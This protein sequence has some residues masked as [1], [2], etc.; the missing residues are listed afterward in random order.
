MTLPRIFAWFS[1]EDYDAIK[2]LS[3]ND[4]DLPDTFDEWLELATQ[5]VANLEANGVAVKKVVINS[6]EFSAYCRA[7][8]VDPNGALRGAFAVVKGRQQ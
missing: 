2:G 4:P 8:G 1:R 5:Q 6:Q 3:P 7:C